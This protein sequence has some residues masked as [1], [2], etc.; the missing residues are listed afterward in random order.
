[1]LATT[2]QKVLECDEALGMSRDDFA[3]LLAVLQAAMASV[4]LTPHQLQLSQFYVRTMKGDKQEAG[5]ENVHVLICPAHYGC[6]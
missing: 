4:S 1:M 2:K 6:Q 3:V 5:A